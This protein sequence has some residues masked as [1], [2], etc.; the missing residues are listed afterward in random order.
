MPS[1][2]ISP[3]VASE[4]RSII[5]A[6]GFPDDEQIVGADHQLDRKAD[7]DRKNQKAKQQPQM[8]R[9]ESLEAARRTAPRRR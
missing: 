3:T 7:P 8:F 9:R 4:W 5:D 6:S 1:T 2:S